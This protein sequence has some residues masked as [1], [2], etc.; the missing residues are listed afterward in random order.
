M[1]VKYKYDLIDN[2]SADDKN[3]G[4]HYVAS[5]LNFILLNFTAE[6]FM[7]NRCMKF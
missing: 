1:V 3:G 4:L 2:L 7:S 5:A 6:L